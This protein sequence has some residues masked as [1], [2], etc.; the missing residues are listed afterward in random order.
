ME[1]KLLLYLFP[2]L[3]GIESFPA[4]S[5]APMRRFYF[6]MQSASPTWKF[7]PLQRPLATSPQT[8]KL[9]GIIFDVDGTLW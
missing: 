9:E 1:D 7:A 2:R 3:F 4:D 5:S 8:R 6:M